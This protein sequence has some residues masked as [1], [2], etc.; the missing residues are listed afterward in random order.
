MA[1]AVQEDLGQAHLAQ[2]LLAVVAMN[3]RNRLGIAQRKVPA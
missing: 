3:A 2:V 1:D